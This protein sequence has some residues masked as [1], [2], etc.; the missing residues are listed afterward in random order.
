V[1]GL[2]KHTLGNAIENV[3][4]PAYT[5][6]YRPLSEYAA[7]VWDRCNNNLIKKIEGTQNRAVRIK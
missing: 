3:K 5:T 1:L 7:D 2:I 4:I 6:L